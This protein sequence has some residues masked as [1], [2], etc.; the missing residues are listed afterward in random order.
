MAPLLLL[1]L[2]LALSAAQEFNPRVVV[3]RNYDMARG[4]CVAVAVVCEKTEKDGEYSVA[5]R[6]ENKVLVSETDYDL[7]VTF[8]LQNIRNGTETHVLALYDTCKKYGLGSQ[9][10]INMIDQDHCYS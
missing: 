9:N 6:G 10:I 4:E 3:Q 8:Y 5:Y 7:Y 2:A 1:S